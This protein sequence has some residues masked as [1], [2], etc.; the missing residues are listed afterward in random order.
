M[1][2]Y[3]DIDELAQMLG[4]SSSSIRRNLAR[5]PFLVPPKMHI[6]GSKMLRWRAR[7]VESWMFE[8]GWEVKVRLHPAP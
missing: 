5:R 1:S 8:T 6:P 3:L 7:D 4:R 2:A